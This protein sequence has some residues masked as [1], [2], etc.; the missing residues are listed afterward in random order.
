MQ[1]QLLE[2][3]EKTIQIAQKKYE[4]ACKNLM[5][6]VAN[7]IHSDLKYLYSVKERLTKKVKLDVPVYIL[8]TYVLS[9]IYNHLMDS[10]VN[11][12]S[13]YCTGV[14]FENYHVPQSIIGFNAK[15]QSPV[16]VVGDSLSINQVL[17]EL[18]DY[19]HTILLQCHKHPGNG[20]ECCY[21]SSLDIDNH[22]GLEEIY[23]V[24]GL[25]FVNDGHF[26]FF[27]ADRKYKIQIY[28]NG[29]RKIGPDSYYFEN[30]G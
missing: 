20:I 19:H 24:I 30:Q 3:T 7:K 22:T 12:K 6:P 29:V 5:F 18:D 21:P 23:P 1:D 8:S 14:I 10:G 2:L 26:R 17:S 15:Y 11:E 13:C 4:N 9:Q 16:R 27:S 28:G 25:I